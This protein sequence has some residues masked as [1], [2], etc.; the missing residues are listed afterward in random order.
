LLFT[1]LLWFGSLL[2]LAGLMIQ[3]EG[4]DEDKDEIYV[5]ALLYFFGLK[6]VSYLIHLDMVT[7]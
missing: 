2:V 5:H 7:A 6:K 3:S 4:E 1:V